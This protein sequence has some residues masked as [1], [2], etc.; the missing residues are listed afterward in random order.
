M[1]TSFCVQTL[2]SRDVA[3]VTVRDELRV[4]PWFSAQE[5]QDPTPVGCCAPA[6]AREVLRDTPEELHVEA[7]SAG[8]R[9]LLVVCFDELRHSTRVRFELDIRLR[10]WGRVAAPLV[11][12]RMRVAAART[13]AAVAR[14]L[15]VLEGAH[16]V[17]L[18]T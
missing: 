5:A 9:A 6:V 14:R 18:V 3:R 8:G 10:G 4:T 13:R 16:R 17:G 15:E 12:L 7:R 1:H 2:A 11:Y